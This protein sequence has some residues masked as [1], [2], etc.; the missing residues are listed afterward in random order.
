[1]I[2]ATLLNALVLLALAAPPA[3]ADSPRQSSITETGSLAPELEAFRPFIGKTYRGEF[4]SKSGDKPAIDI[5]RWERALNGKAIRILHSL[6]QGEYGGESIIFYDKQQKTLR[7][8]Y[9]TTADFY[10]QGEA[11]FDGETFVSTEQVTGH[12]DGITAVVAR[13]YF[14]KDGSLTVES[15]YMKGET[16]SGGSTA[17]YQVVDNMEPQFR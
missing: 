10:T 16:R 12:A 17:R 2:R 8:Y 1:M 15:D 3:I 13:A 6:N 4:T 9:F 7:F 5:S 11:R 14:A